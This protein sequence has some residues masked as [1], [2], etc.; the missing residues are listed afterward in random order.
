MFL[1]AQLFDDWQT[2]SLMLR[3]PDRLTYSTTDIAEYVNR[4][5]TTDKKKL[6]AI[7]TWVAK[8]I[9]YDTDSANNINLG[10]DHEAKITA[11]LR[12]RRG[13]CENYAAIF[14]D[15]CIKSG[16]TSFIVEGYVKQNGV[17][18]RTGHAWCAVFV[19][20]SW[21]LCDPTWDEG[22][23]TTRWFLVPPSE[24]IVT[25][26]PFD[27]MWQLLNYPV[28]H[29]Q[30]YHGDT[31]PDK[32]HPFFNYN[33]SIA[34]Y[35]K[36]DSLQRFISTANRIEQSGLYNKLVHDW[37]GVTKM[38]IEIIRQDKDVD[39]YNASVADLNN[40]TI[41]YND[42][43][44]YRNKQ[45]TPVI[46]DKA[47]QSLLD[48]V[49]TKLSAAH[50]KLDEIERSQ[51]VFK[52]STE[53]IRNRLNALASRVNEQKGFLKL[54]LNTAIANRQSLFYKQVIVKENNK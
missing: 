10:T 20:N 11:A 49:D 15:I 48:G 13:V 25:H 3:I 33:D 36:M 42:F 50:K 53:E 17:V 24:M 5:F 30:F 7:Y 23:S 28:S 16:L 41:I 21:L 52:F 39:L 34:A 32:N 26:M 18:D 43:V 44:E 45:F 12:R 46:T 1:K 37:Q 40:A 4:N 27:P 14:N 54:Y 22:K 19:D 9:R 47:L 2:G 35:I 6:L 29:K 31:Y 38:N 51:A 8:N